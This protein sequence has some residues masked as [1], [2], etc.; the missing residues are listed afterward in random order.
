MHVDG[1]DGCRGV[2]MQEIDIS[3]DLVAVILVALD[4]S[5]WQC[6]SGCSW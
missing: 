2:I 4:G 5:G 1:I 3:Q 6:E